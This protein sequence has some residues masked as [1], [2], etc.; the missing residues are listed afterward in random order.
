V[1]G[2]DVVTGAF[3]FTGRHIAERLLDQGRSVRTLTR[4]QPDPG[5]PLADRVTWAPFR[6][7]D[8]LRESLRGADTLY[9][10]YWVRF[11]RAEVTF[12]AAV[13]NIGRLVA[14]AVDAG[15]RRV[16]HISVANASASSPFPY[17]RGKAQA[18]AVVAGSGLSHAIV[19]PAVVYGPEDI[20]VNNVAWGVRHVP[21]F[22]VPGSG[23]YEVQPVSVY[24]VARIAVDAGARED[25]V[26][27][28]A[29]GARRWSYEEFVRLI[30]SAVGG[31]ARIVRAPFWAALATARVAGALLRDA[32]V[33]RDELESLRAGL[34][35]SNEPPLGRDRFDEWL[36]AHGHE[37]GRAYASEL[38]RNFRNA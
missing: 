17:Y 25:D 37:L 30:R 20:L 24:D 22:L 26:T 21:V 18:E 9:N 34:L 32:V 29:A 19:R 33:T 38:R 10:T 23:R 2:L 4:S 16:V 1:A 15:V 12:T 8:S 11:E 27:L 31:R 13:A 7:D 36:E 6:F 5:H 3:S 14:A 28:D 35:V